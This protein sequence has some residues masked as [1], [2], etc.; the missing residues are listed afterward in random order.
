MNLEISWFFEIPQFI[1]STIFLFC[2]RP[3]QR[4]EPGQRCTNVKPGQPLLN[5][6]SEAIKLP[7]NDKVSFRPNAGSTRTRGKGHLLFGDLTVVQSAKNMSLSL[8][9]HEP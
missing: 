5:Q 8:F 2:S 6:G 1:K 3:G 9:D 7:L 4:V